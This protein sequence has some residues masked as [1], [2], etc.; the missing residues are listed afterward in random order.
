ME[1]P[2]IPMGAI[3]GKPSKEF[4]EETLTAYREKGI[5]QF[6]IYPRSG[7]ELDYM[8]EEWIETCR[9]IIE[10][11]E[12]LGFTSI[13][14]YDEFNWPSGT[15]NKQVPK[16]NPDYAMKQ[17]CV[18]QENGKYEFAVRTNP[19]MTDLM[20]PKA[21]DCFIQK[22]HEEYARNFGKY[23]GTLIKGIFTDEPDI[24]Y[25]SWDHKEDILRMPYYPGLENDYRNIT[26]SDLYNDIRTGLTNK[27]DFYRQTCNQ[28][29]AKKFR[30]NFSEKISTWCEKYNIV[31]TGHLMSESS[32]D[33]AL[34][35]SG[36][37]L[38]VLGGFSQPG[39]DEIFS[40]RTIGSIEWL[41]FGTVMH[42]LEQR[43][44]Q[45]G[46]AELFALGPSDITP[47][48]VRR[49][50]WLASMFGI[51]KYVMAVAQLDHRG[52]TEKKFWFNPFSRTQPWFEAYDALGEEAKIAASYATKKRKYAVEVRYP[53]SSQPITDLLKH[54]TAKQ[55]A[56][57]LLSPEE[58]ATCDV[59]LVPENGN[60]REERT[61]QV[62]FDFE[63]L[64]HELLNKMV[65]SPARVLRTDG[66]LA[67]DVFVRCFDDDTCVVL[68]FSE[69]T[70]QLVLERKGVRT[71]FILPAEGIMAFPGWKVEL[72][73]P[74]TLRVEMI[75]GKFTFAL[76]APCNLRIA[77]RN[78]AGKPELT[79]NGKTIQAESTCTELPQGFREI[80]LSSDAFELSAGEHVIELR[81]NIE[82]FPYLPI[83]W[84]TGEFACTRDKII[85]PYLHDGVGLYG[86][87]GTISQTAK[88]MVP[89]DALK[90]TIDTQGLASELIINGKS[91]GKRLW[92]PFCWIIP[93]EYRGTQV[94]IEIKRYTSCGRIFAERAFKEK[95]AEGWIHHW[96]VKYKPENAVELIPF[97]EL[98][99]S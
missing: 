18:Y 83:A 16:L 53:Y 22:T 31:L 2:L 70:R 52:N 94:D 57:K 91:L 54:L 11:A 59:V 68:D 79:L 30:K 60:I 74:N 32:S 34:N 44:N 85:G 43:G 96:V 47:A 20:N 46:L 17:L 92:D 93:D 88:M 71:D 36:H 86:Y 38:H 56:W 99:F 37:P 87:A 80:Y 3:T 62:F 15:C 72:D 63:F 97:C 64:D 39:M 19:N 23:M 21:V 50:L 13:W 41:T 28:L 48:Q 55:Y 4:V 78:Y 27:S 69:E 65:L 81:N 42:A 89:V 76:S 66:K 12:N 84:I 1:N 82:D 33:K 73:Q 9:W 8:N 6:L 25:F 14:L 61:N 75:D 5:T 67:E 49:Q 90:L 40:H 10:K 35:C 24:A 98:N 26:G 29:F 77:V 51:N 7:C 95:N 58:E 45:G